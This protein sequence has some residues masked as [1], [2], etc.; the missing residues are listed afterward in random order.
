MHQ[1]NA[2]GVTGSH[3]RDTCKRRGTSDAAVMP[4]AG[5][6]RQV[7]GCSHVRA[8]P[9]LEQNG[10][11]LSAARIDSGGVCRGAA[12]N[13]GK[14]SVNMRLWEEW[15]AGGSAHCHR[16]VRCEVPYWRT[17]R[18]VRLYGAWACYCFLACQARKPQPQI[19]DPSCD[20]F[21]WPVADLGEPLC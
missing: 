1:G 8:P 18:L 3:R 6:C 14:L 9:H 15:K 5:R 16:P 11:Q 13:D 20:M 4:A 21:H 17:G 2:V 12:A 10:L 7:T 19:Y